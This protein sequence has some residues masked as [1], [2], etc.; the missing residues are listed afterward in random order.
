MSHAR[1]GLFT[2]LLISGVGY[3]AISTHGDKFYPEPALG[4]YVATKDSIGCVNE[5][6]YI[7][8][9]DLLLDHDLDASNLFIDPLIE[10]GSCGTWNTGEK[11]S[12]NKKDHWP[13][14]K[15][16]KAMHGMICVRPFGR[17]RCF[18]T[19]TADVFPELQNKDA[20]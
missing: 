6:D 12:V 2:L 20:N 5:D 10:I 19:D 1:G 18:W 13:E 11:M 15:M 9:M 16:D 17:P 14:P 4:I 7:R 3:A 8:Y